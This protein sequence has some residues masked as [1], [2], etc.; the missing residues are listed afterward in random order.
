MSEPVDNKVTIIVD[1]QPF[2]VDAGVNLL[3]AC[4]ALEMD[5]PYF[6]W[7]PAMGAV[8][9]CRLCAMT[10]FQN[11]EDTRG[12][13]IMACMTP[14]SEGMI[15]SLTNEKASVF[16]STTI[17]AIMTNHPHDCPVCEEGGDCHLQDMTLI[18]GHIKRRYPGAKRTHLNQ[19]LGPFL[20]HEMNR[21]ISCYRCV[22]YYRDYCGG[23][24]FNV[25][26]SRNNVFFGRAEPGI[27]DNEF[28]G[29]L[30]EVCPTGVFTDKPFSQKFTRKWDL[31]SAPTICTNCSVGCNTYTSERGGVVR[32]V[33]NRYNPQ[34]N[35]HFLCDR[36]RFGYE[37]VNHNDRLEQPWRRNNE[38]QKVD[39]LDMK[40]AEGLVTDWLSHGDCVVV[41]S[42]R[43]SIESNSAL[44]K[45]AGQKN[46]YAGVSDA[47]IEQLNLLSD[48]YQQDHLKLLSLEDIEQCDALLLIG[49]DPTHTAPRL[50]LSIRQMTRNA[51]IEKASKLGIKHWQ[52]EAV[53]NIAQDTRSPLY[54]INSHAS[55]LAD[56]AKQNVNLS[57]ADQL[58][59][60]QDVESLLSEGDKT[61]PSPLALSITNDLL[62]AQNPA[63]VTGTNSDNPALLAVCLRISVLL[64]RRHKRAGFY[65]ASGQINSMALGLMAPEG[66]GLGALMA[67]LE[68]KPPATLVVMET[69]LY[70]YFADEQLDRVLDK[71]KHIIVLDQLMTRTVQMADLVL[72]VCSFAE[73]QG[74]SIN[75]E[76][77]L[78]QSFATM[79]AVGKRLPSFQWLQ[80]LTGLHTHQQAMRWCA[81]SFA[82]LASLNQYMHAHGPGDYDGFIVARQP[83]RSTGR[84][85]INADIDVKEYPPAQDN[86]SPLEF[87]MEGVP[88]FRQKLLT[89]VKTPVTGVWTPKWNSG[90]GINKSLDE[91]AD[92]GIK[93]FNKLT[94]MNVTSLTNREPDINSSD[95]A[96]IAAGHISVS[97][98]HHIYADDELAAY[99]T[100]L[101]QLI[102]TAKVWLSPA[103][104]QQSGINAGDLVSLTSASVTLELPCQIDKTMADDVVLVPT[105]QFLQLGHQVAMTNK[106]DP[107]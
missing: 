5:L 77:R 92:Y 2:Q 90:Q 67:R 106:G 100:S 83:M 51:G 94:N 31:A 101:Q 11:A 47:Q 95:L 23:T 82:P 66:K 6:C 88:A 53:R 36:G 26:S 84:T 103:Q 80:T 33:A 44:I 69:D 37:H 71:V 41:G 59:L 16:R 72:P 58:D 65:C 3:Q 104:A 1:N 55:R 61:R 76:G 105:A 57:P 99:S 21:C 32:K 85:A 40:S 63:I 15:V 35:A 45:M 78:Q 48:I 20:N 81:E 93:L 46:F 96:L 30:A 74:C 24:D 91:E 13:L 49:E 22:R 86:V 60:M 7:H 64:K 54:I 43:S 10:H 18:S 19:Y 102:P 98:K 89:R 73:T 87:S 70:R 68:T 50:A 14:V 12:R 62:T 25:F 34:I 28:S 42:S 56:V 4:L 107:S 38:A 27:L 39:V 52:D 97:P 9:S 17:E 79:P 29:N 75:A 8:G